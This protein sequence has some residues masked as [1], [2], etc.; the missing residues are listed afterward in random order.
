MEPVPY[1]GAQ[2]MAIVEFQEAG[3]Q[4]TQWVLDY[5][6]GGIDLETAIANTQALFTEI[7]EEGYK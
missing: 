3:N 7:S 6:T 2:Y 5:V 4:M 1:V